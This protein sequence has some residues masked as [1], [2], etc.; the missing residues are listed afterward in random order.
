MTLSSESLDDQLDIDD[1]E[2]ESP[3]EHQA[4]DWVDINKEHLLLPTATAHRYEHNSEVREKQDS[5][6]ERNTVDEIDYGA[7][8]LGICL[9]NKRMI[10]KSGEVGCLSRKYDAV[11]SLVLSNFSE[12]LYNL[13]NRKIIRKNNVLFVWTN[14]RNLTF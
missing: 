7:R 12:L 10:G 4:V 1:V 9:L 6:T 11:D 2:G 13:W 14:S 8:N 3:Y 5:K